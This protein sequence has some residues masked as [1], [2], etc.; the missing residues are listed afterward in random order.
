M[1]VLVPAALAVGI[2]SA[3]SVVSDHRIPYPYELLSVGIIYG[4][5]GLL[6]T[7]SE[8]IGNTVAWAYL[9]ALVLAP[10]Q[11]DLLTLF[12]KGLS[13]YTATGPNAGGSTATGGAQ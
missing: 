12:S 3:R 9:V 11:A 4:G 13:T 8:P 2:V 7:A 10:R 1:S 6:A 5:A